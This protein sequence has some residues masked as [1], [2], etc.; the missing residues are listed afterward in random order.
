MSKL[1]RPKSSG[2][3]KLDKHKEEII[4]LMKNGSTKVFICKR[5]NC[6]KPTL[7]N[8]M[9]KNMIFEQIGRQQDK[10]DSA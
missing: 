1:G 3:S 7:Y 9:K 8:W 2:K 6:S 10:N 5:Y 4:A